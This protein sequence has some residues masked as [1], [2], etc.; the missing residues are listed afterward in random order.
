MSASVRFRSNIWSEFA[1]TKIVSEN[2]AATTVDITLAI[3][4]SESGRLVYF[5]GVGPSE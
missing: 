4:V 5:R 3:E 1:D 2:V